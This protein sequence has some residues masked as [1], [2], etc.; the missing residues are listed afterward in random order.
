MI[1][2]TELRNLDGGLDVRS[3][4]FAELGKASHV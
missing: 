3:L 4:D 2:A 1:S